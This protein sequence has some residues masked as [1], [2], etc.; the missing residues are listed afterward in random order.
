MVVLVI[1]VG[2]FVRKIN[3]FKLL[4]V[5]VFLVATPVWA[6]DLPQCFSVVDPDELCTIL[7][8][9]DNVVS[10]SYFITESNLLAVPRCSNSELLTYP[11]GYCFPES[12]N[13]AGNAGKLASSY[14]FSDFL[15]VDNQYRLNPQF[16]SVNHAVMKG[17]E[18]NRQQSFNTAYRI[19]STFIEKYPDLKSQ[20][21]SAAGYG[22]FETTTFNLLLYAGGWGDGMVFDNVEHKAIYVDTARVGTG[23]G[24][25]YITEYTL[26]VFHSH[27]GIEQYFGASAGGD[28]G[29]SATIAIWSKAVSF[30]PTIS[31]Y[32]I[33]RT[34]ANIQGNWGGTVYWLS[35]LLN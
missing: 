12:I 3:F 13:Y 34:G 11:Q 10:P 18:R 8:N 31:T 6:G 4:R 25:G 28:I 16:S 27:F 1:K 17:L 22:V 33:Y 15:V 5:V 19:L 20:L 26:I 9:Q 2:S 32:K 7:R 30:N 23:L 29:A 35:P 24:L 14:K 21:E